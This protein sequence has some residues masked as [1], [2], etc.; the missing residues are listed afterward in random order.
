MTRRK[1]GPAI[2]LR[3]IMVAID[4][5]PASREILAHAASTARHY[6]SK[7]YI[8]HVVPGDIYNAVPPELMAEAVKQKSAEVRTQMD[9]LLGVECVAPIKH[10]A[11]V[12][13]GPVA[14]TLL[15][16]AARYRVDLLV[17]GTRGQHGLDRLLQGSVAEGVFRMAPC[18]VL[19]VPPSDTEEIEH[20][21][22]PV[23]NVLYPT[24]FSENSLRAAPYA[25]SLARRHRARL[26]LLHVLPDAGIQSPD[27]FARLAAPV[28]KRL[29]DL[30][31]DKDSAGR[32]PLACV[33][34]G[35]A[36]ERI[37]RV[38]V[39]Y[40]AD[41]IVLGIAAAGEAAAHLAGGV[42][43]TIV[44]AAPCPVLTIRN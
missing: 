19:I 32:E 25:L 28:E 33:E 3:N 26:I 43:Y 29:R 42:T 30:L 22:R 36:A 34:F 14:A 13:Q 35:P 18:P 15:Q 8:A 11:L 27:D 4:F 31:P 44:L 12:E 20:R 21:H 17:L 7:L 16:L 37:V 5:S 40:R 1:T 2:R 6:R 23:H 38:A 10:E 24:S 41:L 39:E 9:D